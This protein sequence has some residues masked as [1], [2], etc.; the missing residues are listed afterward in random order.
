MPSD[1][2]KVKKGLA[3]YFAWPFPAT[4]L[5][6]WFTA[7]IDKAMEIY[8]THHV[9]IGSHPAYASLNFTINGYILD[10]IILMKVTYS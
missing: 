1:H 8:L 6:V 9:H 2:I 7:L 5:R 4:L 10:D 3:M